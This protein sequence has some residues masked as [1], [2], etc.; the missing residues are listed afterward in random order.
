MN[1]LVVKLR[2]LMLNADVVNLEL[3]LQMLQ[4]DEDT[5]ANEMPQLGELANELLYLH[6]FHLPGL[7]ELSQTKFWELRS[8]VQDI[9]EEAT[10]YTPASLESSDGD[11]AEFTGIW[12]HYGGNDFC[13][14]IS[15]ESYL[16]DLS[17]NIKSVPHVDIIELCEVMMES[18]IE[19]EY[20]GE[21][22]IKNVGRMFF[23]NYAPQEKVL[24]LLKKENKPNALEHCDTYL[25]KLSDRWADLDLQYINFTDTTFETYPNNFH[26][27]PN[28]ETLI[29]HGTRTSVD[30]E[31]E[32]YRNPEDAFVRLSELPSSL[33]NL[34]QLK[35]LDLGRTLLGTPENPSEIPQW[36]VK[37]QSLEV[38]YL[39]FAHL[40]QL[41]NILQQLSSLQQLYIPQIELSEAEETVWGI[42]YYDEGKFIEL[43]DEWFRKR[44]PKCEI[45]IY[46]ETIDEENTEWEDD[47]EI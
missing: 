44:L 26:L 34:P 40:G 14:D 38:L 1:P 37:L 7:R 16:F 29:L 43:D 41:P 21:I 22:P 4:P 20:A 25:L 47:T 23:C 17:E 10:G 35:Y 6:F 31:S 13:Q 33:A 5:S 18:P 15:F 30:Y 36:L 9:F 12:E 39:P 11:F 46:E 45:H 2:R 32:E 28:L 24:A 27:F 19:Y 3:A 42:R 8:Q